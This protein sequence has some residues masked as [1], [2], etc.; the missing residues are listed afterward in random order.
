VSLFAEDTKSR[1]PESWSVPPQL[2]PYFPHYVE[3]VR[4]SLFGDRMH[5]GLWAS[6]KGG[7]L[8]GDRIYNIARG[9]L[10]VRF[11]K[12]MAL[13]D[14]RRAAA[15]YVA[16]EAPEKLGLIPGLLH[17]ASPDVS[18]QHYNLAGSIAAG[19]RYNAT[20]ARL[21]SDLRSPNKNARE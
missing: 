20:M 11:G 14:F 15:T 9:R 2:V 4:P 12:K 13:H 3:K 1:R 8:T 5:N 7:P 10:K 17:H 21:R 6:M 19:Q 16:I 18:D